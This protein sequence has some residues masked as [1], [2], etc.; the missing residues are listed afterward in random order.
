LEKT[1]GTLAFGGN[2]AR[3][4]KDLAI[5][6][7]RAASLLD[8]LG[9]SHWASWL[10]QSAETLDRGDIEGAKSFLGAFGGMGSLNDCYGYEPSVDL[11]EESEAL[12]PRGRSHVRACR[13]IDRAWKLD[14]ELVKR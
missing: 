5:T 10:R 3:R 2:R 8:E 12:A 4:M 13:E 1:I 11:P 7:H 14:R 6:L 9:D